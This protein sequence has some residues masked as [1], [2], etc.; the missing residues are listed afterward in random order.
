MLFVWSTFS[1]RASSLCTDH[2]CK[3]LR[4]LDVSGTPKIKSS[5][6]KCRMEI[7][8]RPS[9]CNMLELRKRPFCVFGRWWPQ[10]R[11]EGFSVGTNL[12][13]G[14]C[15][16]N[17]WPSWPW[18]PILVRVISL[19]FWEVRNSMSPRL[20]SGISYGKS[21]LIP[22][23]TLGFRRIGSAPLTT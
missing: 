18:G 16:G 11:Q 13:S 20:R 22:H 5:W 4:S 17:T 7:V 1:D 9:N 10:P 8:W 21:S 2:V 19:A 6:P 15:C 23:E 3:V 14:F 12:A